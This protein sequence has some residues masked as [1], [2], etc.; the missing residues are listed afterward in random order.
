VLATAPAT[1]TLNS[2]TFSVPAGLTKLS[3]GLKAGDK[4]SGVM[5]RNG[6]NVVELKPE[7]F[8]F[9]GSPGTY[10]FNAFVASS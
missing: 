2:Q 8:I 6:N 7:G 10:N 9:N 5:S 3:V 4:M 1:V